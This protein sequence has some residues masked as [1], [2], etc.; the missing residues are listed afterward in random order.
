MASP[1]ARTP[2]SPVHTQKINSARGNTP[3]E[4]L[5][6][7]AT[8]PPSHEQRA[9]AD[10]TTPWSARFSRSLQSLCAELLQSGEPTDGATDSRARALAQLDATLRSNPSLASGHLEVLRSV[11]VRLTTSAHELQPE[12]CAFATRCLAVHGEQL[13]SSVL[14]AALPALLVQ[15]EPSRTESF[16]IILS[17]RVE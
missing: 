2:L 1:R 9:A 10:P 15:P 16:K 7:V 14:S 13:G 3:S 8:P 6:V 11:L 5:K 17:K 12:V 4:K